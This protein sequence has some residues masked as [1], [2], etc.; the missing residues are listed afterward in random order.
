MATSNDL[1]PLIPEELPADNALAATPPN[2][3]AGEGTSP[4]VLD[5]VDGAVGGLPDSEEYEQILGELRSARTEQAVSARRNH[6]LVLDKVTFGITGA[7]AVA[8]VVWGFVGRDSLASSSTVALNWVMEYT[9]WLF[10]LLASLFV[11][12]VLWLAW[13]SSATSRWAKTAKNPNSVPFPGS[14]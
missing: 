6:K 14:R 4:A 5:P 13:A 12:F 10:M 2:A 7:I 1:K 8:F 3:P 9:G 11:V